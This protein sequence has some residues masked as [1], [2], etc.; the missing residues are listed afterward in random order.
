MKILKYYYIWVDGYCI[1][2]KTM[3]EANEY[4]KLCLSKGRD[5]YIENN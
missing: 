3:E 5:A 1:M 4:L 2:R